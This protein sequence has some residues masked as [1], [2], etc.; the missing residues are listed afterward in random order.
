[1]PR[2][3]KKE[4]RAEERSLVETEVAF[5][6]GND[7]YMASSVDISKMGIRIVTEKPID[8]LFQ[9]KENDKLVQY[10]AKLVW[11]RVKD[12]GSMEYGLRY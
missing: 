12:D 10:D 11:A 6:T 8:I 7:I 1:M 3:E 4:K 2:K 9:I 5:H